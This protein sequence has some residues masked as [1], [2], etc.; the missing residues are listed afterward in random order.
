M[1]RAVGVLLL[2][3][4]AA[5]LGCAMCASPHDQCGPVSSGNCRGGCNAAGREGSVLSG[6]A[7]AEMVSDDV[8]GERIVSQTDRKADAA[9]QGQPTPAAPPKPRAESDGWKANERPAGKSGASS[10][11]KPRY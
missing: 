3:L 8:E 11:A 9:V 10:V 5:A 2:S 7:G 1:R 4:A 6:V